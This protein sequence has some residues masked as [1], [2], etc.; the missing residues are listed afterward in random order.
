[1]ALST[2]ST[3]AVAGGLGGVGKTIVEQLHFANK[4][5]LLVFTRNVSAVEAI[6]AASAGGFLFEYHLVGTAVDV[7]T[8]Y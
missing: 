2:M 7:A 1:M 8:L 4:Y 5:N 3:L 6:S